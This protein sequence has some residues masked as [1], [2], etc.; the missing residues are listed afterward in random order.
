MSAR[1]SFLRSRGTHLLQ[2]QQRHAA[3]EGTSM[4][5]FNAAYY[6]PLQPARF[7][8]QLLANEPDVGRR[9]KRRKGG[10]KPPKPK[11]KNKENSEAYEK[12]DIHN[13][14]GG[15][16]DE[17][18]NHSSLPSQLRDFK[19]SERPLIDRARRNFQIY[20]LNVNAFPTG[21]QIEDWSRASYK[22]AAMFI[23][24]D[25]FESKRRPFRCSTSKRIDIEQNVRRR[26]TLGSKKWQVI[27]QYHPTTFTNIDTVI[28][29]SSPSRRG[30][31][32]V[33]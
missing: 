4:T 32:E 25:D 15:S 30:L 2:T 20:L 28:H 14:E 5:G 11:E 7:D 27:I 9:N 19:A 12:F 24:G 31:S 3:T 17:D 29:T 22:H 21:E 23:Y 26:T 10:R 16:E 13:I 1:V 6:T 33:G 18:E 8:E